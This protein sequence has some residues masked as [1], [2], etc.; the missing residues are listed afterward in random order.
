MIRSPPKYLES[1][2]NMVIGFL[3]W[4]WCTEFI[5]YERKTPLRRSCP[6][7]SLRLVRVGTCLIGCCISSGLVHW[8]Y[9]L[10]KMSILQSCFYSHILAEDVVRKWLPRVVL[11]LLHCSAGL[12]FCAVDGRLVFELC[13]ARHRR[14][15]G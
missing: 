14:G 13:L 12:F 5:R 9:M 15:N 7:T 1:L 10:N 6:Q 8:L 11:T 3:L 4:T 2:K